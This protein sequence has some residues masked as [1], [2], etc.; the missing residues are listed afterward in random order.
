MNRT[1][2]SSNP[3]LCWVIYV[4][5]AYFAITE[6]GT[7]IAGGYTMT[8]CADVD[9]AP[10]PIGVDCRS[11]FVPV[12]WEFYMR[13]RWEVSAMFI[14]TAVVYSYH[15]RALMIALFY[16]A[17]GVAFNPIAP[18]HL[19]RSEWIVLDRIAQGLLLL[20]IAYFIKDPPTSG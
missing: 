19:L 11:W 3:L 13:L 7:A 9:Y 10:M 6:L 17:V 4:G 20:S 5:I 14:A 16:V 12:S 1:E 8:R 15:F 18:L 2:K